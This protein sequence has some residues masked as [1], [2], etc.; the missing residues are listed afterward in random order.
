MLDARL[1]PLIQRTH[2]SLSKHLLFQRAAQQLSGTKMMNI[3]SPEQCHYCPM[4]VNLERM[5]VKQNREHFMWNGLILN[6][7]NFTNHMI[8][9]ML[10]LSGL[11][12]L[13]IMLKYQIKIRFGV[14]DIIDSTWCW[15]DCCQ[16]VCFP[17]FNLVT[18]VHVW[19]TEILSLHYVHMHLSASLDER[20]T[21]IRDHRSN[22]N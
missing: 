6:S 7:S 18:V 20:R 12:T 8:S 14:A 13:A 1:I 11:S 5:T 9:G 19:N 22:I 2:L 3:V 17:D 16:H 10:A 21:T 15:F 4:K